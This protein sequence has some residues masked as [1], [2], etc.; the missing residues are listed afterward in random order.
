MIKAILLDVEGTTT[1]ID[2]VHKE[3]FPY[4]VDK[5]SG[6]IN[7]PKNSEILRPIIIEI[8]ETL[9]AEGLSQSL[10]HLTESEVIISTLI[11]WVRIDRKHPALKKVQGFIWQKGYESGEIKGH[12]YDDVKEAFIKWTDQNLKVGIYSSG[13]VLA[14][15]LLFKYSLEGDLTSFLSFHFDTKIGL[16]R[17]SQSYMNITK[18]IGLNSNEILFISDIPEELMAAR[19]AGLKAIHILRPGTSKHPEFSSIVKF[20]DLKL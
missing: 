2:F 14:Q 10:E 18:E 17:E 8:K 6:F 4:S 13:S 1:S 19:D 7:D 11:E 16:K 15:K 3:L 20:S 12:I 5:I 9:K